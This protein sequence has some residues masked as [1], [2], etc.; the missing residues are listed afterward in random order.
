MGA[1][2]REAALPSRPRPLLLHRRSGSVR[3]IAVL[4]RP[5]PAS[6][7]RVPIL[8]ISATAEMMAARGD[9]ACLRPG[10]LCL[11]CFSVFDC[12]AAAVYRRRDAEAAA[13]GPPGR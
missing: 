8:C 11:L 5:C 7:S 1:P 6:E 9:H 2:R 10:A 4:P 3:T 13:A 12:G